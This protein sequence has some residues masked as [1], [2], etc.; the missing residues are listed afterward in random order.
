MVA[1]AALAAAPGAGHAAELTSVAEALTSAFPPPAVTEKR[2]LYLDER[3]AEAVARAAGSRLPSRVIT[4]YEARE[5]QAPGAPVIGW[6]CLDTH[7]VRT[8]PETLMVVVDT[9]LEVRRVEVLAFKE[10]RD[11]LLPERWL[12]QLEGG[13]LSP[14]LALKRDVRVMSGATLSSRAATRATRRVLALVE[15]ELAPGTAEDRAR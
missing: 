15:R 5:S 14:E 12:E 11:Y 1:G 4:C 8:L 7:V 3:Q 10:P 6:A 13:R 2:T 9:G